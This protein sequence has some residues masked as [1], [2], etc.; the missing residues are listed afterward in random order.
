MLLFYN[1]VYQ[2]AAVLFSMLLIMVYICIASE[3]FLNT[4]MNE[5]IIKVDLFY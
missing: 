1:K 3:E 5:H 2:L 4:N